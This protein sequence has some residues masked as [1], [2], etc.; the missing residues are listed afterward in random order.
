MSA[1]LHDTPTA[2]E[3]ERLVALERYGL[4]DTPAERDFDDLVRLA[5][6]FCEAPLALLTLVD[7]TRQ[8]FKARIGVAPTETLRNISFCAH[9]IRQ[10]GGLIVPDLR[11]DHRF[12][13]NPFVTGPP[14]V[15]FYAGAPLV[16]PD[17]HAL[18]TLCVLDLVPRRLTQEQWESLEALAAQAMAQMELRRRTAEQDRERQQ[19]TRAVREHEHQLQI[20]TNN[21]PVLIARVDADRRYQFANQAYQTLLGIAPEQMLGRT[22]AEVLGG[23]AYRVIQPYVDRVLAG[24]PV[25]YEACVPFPASGP[26]FL[27]LSY[28][29]ERGPDGVVVGFVLS[30]M[31]L[32]ERRLAEEAWR[33]SETRLSAAIAAL[34]VI[35]WAIDAEGI[36]TRSDG[37]ALA[38][39]G[40]RP[41]QVVGQSVFDVYAGEPALVG[42]IREALAGERDGWISEVQGRVFDTRVSLLLDAEGRVTGL[43][44]VS[45]DVTGRRQAEEALREQHT[46]LRRVLDNDPNFIFVKDAE[47]RFLLANNAVADAYGTTPEGL[48]GRTDADFNPNAEEVAQFRR[49]EQELLASSQGRSAYE[50]AI[51]DAAGRRRWLQTVKCSIDAPEVGA[52]H[53]L[54]VC[55]DI[56]ERK[57]LEAERERLLAEALDRADHDPLTGLL[58]HRAFHKRLEDEADRAQ[59]AGLSLAVAMLDLNN[60]KFFNDAYGHQAGDDV[61]RRVTAALRHGCRSYDILGR[62]GGDEFVILM[63]GICVEEVGAVVGRLR[64]SLDRLGYRPPGHD[65]DIPLTLSVGVAV[66]P[67]E[68]VTRQD[69]VALA[70]ARLYRVKSG[71]EASDRAEDLRTAMS[72]A[73]AGFSMLDALV[74]AVDNKD[75][76]TRR[77]SEDVMTY[78][79]QIADAQELEA[80]ERQT[81]AV[82]ALLHDVGKIGVPD[83]V[84]RKP[85]RLNE[86]ETGAMQ[87]HPE[88]GAVIVQAV[89]GFEDTLGAIRHHHERWDGGGYPAGLS[90]EDIPFAAR[91]MAVADAFS[92]MTTDRPYRKGMAHTTALD[93]LAQGAGTQ[94]DPVCVAT[95]LRARASCV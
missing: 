62:F 42:C 35:V 73:L 71:G 40:L 75:R 58:N 20:I 64:A 46:F 23:D 85:G 36:F 53:I 47:G 10:P 83:S 25:T 13:E 88:M 22:L 94:W 95:F 82:A 21:V 52:R 54:G 84:L 3:D 11:L 78:C 81:L 50:E 26:R 45:H 39:I 91:I 32:T 30:A 4:L 89:P 37:Q 29:P 48:M 74:A 68:A 44:G 66:F 33:E 27:H 6:R 19:E 93:V 18:G 57:R 65:A 63:P 51:T 49:S 5:A 16:T 67:D 80:G 7:G 24:E 59:R 2:S 76:Y 31:D 61:L 8:W 86:A 55:T 9:A 79:L 69:V 60:F 87:Q 34:P 41:G 14:H 17:G 92:A 38:S 90:G 12:T 77:H 43:L 15:R 28:V 72:T 56:T 1:L 70:D